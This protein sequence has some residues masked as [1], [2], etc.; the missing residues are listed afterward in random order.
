MT[1]EITKTPV[2]FDWKSL[3]SEADF[4]ATK[5][6]PAVVFNK[7]DPKALLPGAAVE[8]KPAYRCNRC[9]GTGV[10]RFGYHNPQSGPCHA[11]KGTGGF[12]SSPEARSKAKAARATKA[13]KEE[14]RI[15]E[16]VADFRDANPDVIEALMKGANKG[17]E[18]CSSLW[19]QLHKTGT[20]SEKQ[21]DA[22]RRGIAKLA[23]LIAEREA[24]A[25]S[26]A[27]EGV[28][29]LVSAFV[30][31]KQSGLK[32]PKVR[33]GGLIFSLAG[34]A[35][36]NAGCLYVK[37]GSDYVGKVT[38]AGKWLKVNACT[39]ETDALVQAVCTDPKGQ[40]VAHG[41]KTGSCSCCGRELTD[42]VS[43]ANG[44]GP[45]CQAHFGW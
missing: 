17:N 38:P 8:G 22:V 33:I 23:T 9:N 36:A 31:A 12:K 32:F 5:A 10:F 21:V 39:P 41:L 45:K 28:H 44:I 19:A 13:A 40:A 4:N 30:K 35:S 18:F 16:A 29:A 27:G 43:V 6:G 26:V 3:E 20:L 25:P 14:G 2:S 24:S 42:P 1:T 37:S 11:C 7:L 34:S 15:A